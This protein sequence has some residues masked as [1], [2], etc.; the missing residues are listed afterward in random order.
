MSDSEDV[1]AVIQRHEAEWKARHGMTWQEEFAL[2]PPD[3]HVLQWVLNA[4]GSGGGPIRSL[5]MINR[6][7]FEACD[8]LDAMDVKL[9]GGI[10]DGYFYKEVGKNLDYLKNAGLVE[11]SDT[12]CSLT[13]RG[14]RAFYNTDY[15]KIGCVIKNVKQYWNDMEEDEANALFYLANPGFDR[16]SDAFKAV[17][18]R[19][20]DLV[21]RLVAKGKIS[22]GRATELL[23]SH[24]KSITRS[25]VMHMMSAAGL[26]V[27]R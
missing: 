17:S 1:D 27:F 18:G 6:I 16:N 11:F 21:M 7:L 22:G 25:D 15:D 9:L 3:A 8:E 20:V 10:E 26:R 23:R 19:L 24:D 5:S 12:G 4:L 13:E 14:W 2:V